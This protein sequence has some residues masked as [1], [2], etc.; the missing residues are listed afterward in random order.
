MFQISGANSQIY[1][2]SK[3][4]VLEKFS[5]LEVLNFPFST[6]KKER[7][8]MQGGHQISYF[9]TKARSENVYNVT[10]YDGNSGSMYLSKES[11][12]LGCY[13]SQVY[14]LYCHI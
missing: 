8:S 6:C 13:S 4:V 11:S 12:R 9:N 3:R 5:S 14:A 2:D 7:L 10:G 1:R